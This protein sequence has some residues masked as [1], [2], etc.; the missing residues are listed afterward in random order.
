MRVIEG[1]SIE[2]VAKDYKVPIEKILEYV[3]FETDS[4]TIMP[5]KLPSDFIILPEGD[6][7]NSH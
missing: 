7:Q 2:Q 4:I 1:Y 5:Y 6:K 3:K